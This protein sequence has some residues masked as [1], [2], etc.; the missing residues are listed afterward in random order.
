MKTTFASI[1][2]FLAVRALAAPTDITYGP[3]A[4]GW[5]SIDYPDGTG[6]NLHEYPAP[7]GEWESV[8]YPPGT[9]EDPSCSTPFKF[10]STYNVV[11]I[12][13]EVRNGTTPAPGPKEAVGFF[14][15]GINSDMDTICYVRHLLVSNTT[16]LSVH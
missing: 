4:N 5:E 15:F 14:N 10:T 12:G 16:V 3:P 2:A 9:G 6:E 7:P 13:S 1:A 11:A 8:K